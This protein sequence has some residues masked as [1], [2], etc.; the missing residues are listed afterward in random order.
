MRRRVAA[1]PNLGERGEHRA[2]RVV[3]APG[4]CRREQCLQHD[5]GEGV[6]PAGAGSFS[7]G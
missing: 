2:T 5:H 6:V 7:E 4:F 1:Q 3:A